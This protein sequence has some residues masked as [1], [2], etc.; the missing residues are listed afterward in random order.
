MIEINLKNNET[1]KKVFINGKY[2]Y[3]DIPQEKL[4]ILI[5]VLERQLTEYEKEK[6]END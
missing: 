1:N 2:N 5:S 4:Y 6:K 3:K